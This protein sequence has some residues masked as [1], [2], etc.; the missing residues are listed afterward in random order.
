MQRILQD[1]QAN[2]PARLAYNTV[3]E[4]YTEILLQT[5]SGFYRILSGGNNS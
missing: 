5:L 3:A 4:T 2:I 1:N